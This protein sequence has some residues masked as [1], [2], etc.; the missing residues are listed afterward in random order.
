MKAIV[1]IVGIILV[2]VACIVDIRCSMERD[3]GHATEISR[4]RGEIDAGAKARMQQRREGLELQIRALRLQ[5][6]RLNK[7]GRDVE[8]RRLTAEIIRLNSELERISDD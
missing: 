6:R 1:I 3:R 8:S 4:V 2:V 5:A 7:E